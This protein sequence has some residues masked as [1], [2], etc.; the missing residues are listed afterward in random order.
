MK[1]QRVARKLKLNELALKVLLPLYGSQTESM[2]A[3]EAEARLQELRPRRQVSC[4]L[5]SP[6]AWERPTLELSVIV[7]TWNNGLWIDACLDSV[8]RQQ[9]SYPF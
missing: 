5:A 8:L 3:E 6:R 7:P 1:W 9:T 2:T 4:V